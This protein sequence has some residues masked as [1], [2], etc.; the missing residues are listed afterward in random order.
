MNNSIAKII[1]EHLEDQKE[2]LQIIK[3]SSK[4]QKNFEIFDRLVA[5]QKHMNECYDAFFRDV[6]G[7]SEN[8]RDV[9]K[10]LKGLN[11][12]MFELNQ[13][14]PVKITHTHHFDKKSRNQVWLMVLG[15]LLIS[16]ISIISIN[17]YRD[18]TDYK[19]AWE[20][21]ENNNPKEQKYFDNVLKLVKEGN[22]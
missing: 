5:E 11:N 2:V 16:T 22:N 1:I 20:Y 10:K 4:S 21:I 18:T 3:K 15:I 14:I 19:K 6:D 12:E 7:V 17:H 9:E 13:K 8:L